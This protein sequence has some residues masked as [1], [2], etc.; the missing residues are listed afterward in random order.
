MDQP[1]REA[2]LLDKQRHNRGE[3]IAHLRAHGRTLQTLACRLSD[4]PEAIR[5][6]SPTEARAV[7]AAV[8]CGRGI[9]LAEDTTDDGSEQ[10]HS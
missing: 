8:L 4:D 2:E 5:H 9:L 10:P 3:F 6:L 7:T 1:D